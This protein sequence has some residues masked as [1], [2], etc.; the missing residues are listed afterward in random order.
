MARPLL[1]VAI[2]VLAC[3][4]RS[5]PA[6]ACDS[7]AARAGISDAWGAMAAWRTDDFFATAAA[8]VGCPD[9]SPAERAEILRIQGARSAGHAS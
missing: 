5:S 2:G 1:P 9:N 8:L 6:L 4:G 3:I 7:T